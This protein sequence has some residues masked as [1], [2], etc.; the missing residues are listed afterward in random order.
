[1]SVTHFENGVPGVP[2]TY[3]LLSSRQKMLAAQDR[4]GDLVFGSSAGLL[5]RNHPAMPVDTDRFRFVAT[6]AAPPSRC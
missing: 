4:F 6:A 1:M 3:F 5:D 2:A